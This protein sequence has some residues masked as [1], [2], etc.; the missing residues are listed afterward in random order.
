MGDDPA[1]H[2]QRDMQALGPGLLQ[3]DD[4][5]I[6]RV[7]AVVDGVTD[8]AINQAL[9][10]TLRPR[11]ATLRP[12]RP[13][14]LTRLL[15]IP[16]DP[17]T[18]PLR[19][20]RP[21][22][23]TVPRPVLVPIAKI[24]RSGL[25]DLEPVINGI[26]A[27][28]K[29]D[30]AQ[31]ITQAGE[32]LWPRAAAILAT[33]PPPADWADTGLPPGAYQPLAANIA[34]VLRRASQL[35]CLALDEQQG[36]LATDSSAVT[37]ILANI[38]NES[39]T[40]CA[41]IARLILVQSPHALSVL[42][43]IAGAGR[44]SDEKNVLRAAMDTAVGATLTHMERDSGFA[45]EIGHGALVETGVEVRRVLTLLREI[46]A[47][48]SFADHWP[49][50]TAI[51]QKLDE[52]CGTRFARGVREGLVVPLTAAALPVDGPAQTALEDSARELRKLE[53]MARKVGDHAGYD[54][55]LRT[56]TDAVLAAADAGT[57][58]PMR[59]YR[60]IEILAGAEAA[61]ALYFKACGGG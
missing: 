6:R 28:H 59:K 52:V 61:E 49:R 14:R 17:L 56:A 44:T 24:V 48:K 4:H 30:A 34:A 55:L 23:P 26:I 39:A 47:D 58:T 12:V 41:M 22:D 21:S 18:G 32:L 42:D 1:K 40:A 35:R 10:E 20:W 13:L 37:D 45:H 43:S 2:T 16:L 33:A 27:G 7:L 51:R 8:P 53:T 15:F 3:A 46:E 5:K 54:A 29:A 57:L 11:L 9:L 25:G 50:L 19:G 38:T 31:A 36:G 60:L